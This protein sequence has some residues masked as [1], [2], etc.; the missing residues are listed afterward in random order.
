MSLKRN[1]LR[2]RRELR[3][4]LDRTVDWFY[5]IDTVVS[6]QLHHATES[7]RFG[8]A[9]VNGPVSYW[10]LRSYLACKNLRP[11]EVFYDIGCGHGRVLCM[12]ARHRVSK[13]IGIELS[14]EFA[15]KAR[16]NAAALRGRVSP[17]E[18]RVGDAAE[19]DYT[20]ST[21]FYFGD[22]FGAETMRA[23]LKRIGGTISVKPRAVRCIFV[24]PV[25]ER[26]EAVRRVCETSGWLSFVGGKSLW[27]SPMRVEY[28]AWEPNRAGRN[29]RDC[30]GLS[31]SANGSSAI[32][33]AA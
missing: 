11:E 6:T 4:G 24:L 21:T 32:S 9:H 31:K 18:I 5:S 25:W 28:W 8:D 7:S 17:I 16:A 23:V 22:P 2:A 29:D 14:T 12:V 15:A 19:M 27:Y 10:I 13:C 1:A 20:D 26:S 33:S 3:L 30:L